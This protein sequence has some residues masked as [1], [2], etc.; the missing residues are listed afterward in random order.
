MTKGGGATGS[1]ASSTDLEDNY[2]LNNG[3]RSGNVYVRGGNDCV[4]GKCIENDNDSY[5]QVSDSSSLDNILDNYTVELWVK[6]KD[7][8]SNRGVFVKGLA[9][10]SSTLGIHF[11][12]SFETCSGGGFQFGKSQVEDCYGVPKINEWVHIVYMQKNS[13]LSI[14]R[15]GALVKN[16]TN[17]PSNTSNDYALT[18][19]R[20]GTS[21]ENLNG[22]LD[23][24]RL[25]KKALSDAQIKQNYIAGLNSLLAKGGIS[26]E[27]Y[28]QRI[29]SLSQ[30]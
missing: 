13:I 20:N 14:Y 18:L 10:S 6:L 26:K 17:A 29:E 22:F 16:V 9:S 11:D 19:G 8:S 27:E 4:K 21:G 23:E 30:N 7:I 28:N 1:L 15:N 3:S 12:A 24:I 25:Y 2:G 5:V